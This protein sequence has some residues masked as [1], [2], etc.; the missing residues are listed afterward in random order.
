MR[1]EPIVEGHGEVAAVPLLLRRLCVEAQCQDIEVGRPIRWKRGD[2]VKQE[3]LARAV[4]LALLRPECK[5]ILIVFDS[6]RDCPRDLA[7]RLTNWARQV[8]AGVPCEVV[9]AHREYEAWF[10]ANVE[11]LRG[12]RGIRTDAKPHPDPES[13][14]GAKGQLE[15]RMEYGASYIERTDQP[16][17]T[18]SFDMSLA[19]RRCRSF[20]KLVNAFAE[21]P[22][23][24]GRHL[25]QW[26]PSQ[27][28]GA[29]DAG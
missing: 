12:K 2:L 7:P 25:S 18:Q 23:G 5:A 27:W 4:R 26:P 9:M 11:S 21:L 22:R 24:M 6:D 28:T 29:P 10:L 14:R 3:G 19:Y 8:A 15:Q 13:P 17:L 1:I 20:R 16:A